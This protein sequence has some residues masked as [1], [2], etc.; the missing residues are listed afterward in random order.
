MHTAKELLAKLTYLT[1]VG[2]EDGELQWIGTRD[3]WDK[4]DEL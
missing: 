1:L 2:E 4:V 3:Q